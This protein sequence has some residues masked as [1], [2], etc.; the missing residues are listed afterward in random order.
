MINKNTLCFGDLEK[1]CYFEK[2]VCTGA[3]KIR[4]SLERQRGKEQEVISDYLAICRHN[5]KAQGQEPS[6]REAQ[7]Q[8]ESSGSS[9]NQPEEGSHRGGGKQGSSDCCRA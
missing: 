3:L 6:R 1:G 5:S 2:I 7:L 9:G 4:M 8:Q